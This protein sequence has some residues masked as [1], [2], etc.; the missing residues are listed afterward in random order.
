M[1]SGREEVLD[2]RTGHGCGNRE[3]INV[4]VPVRGR[5][6]H[7]GGERSLAE[8]GGLRF[9]RTNSRTQTR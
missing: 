5:I 7:V 3:K 1:K 6:P 9:P 4:F 2:T 8:W